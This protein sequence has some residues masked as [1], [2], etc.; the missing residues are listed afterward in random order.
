MVEFDREEVTRKRNYWKFISFFFLVILIILVLVLLRGYQESVKLINASYVSGIDTGV[1]QGIKVGL[2]QCPSC[3]TCTTTTCP[4]C[5]SPNQT[6]L[7]IAREQTKTG[8]IVLY[9]ETHIVSLPIQSLCNQLINGSI[10][11]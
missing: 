1:K 11:K 8:N 2:S 10:P 4:V 7:N 5:E 9:N 6:V 3:P